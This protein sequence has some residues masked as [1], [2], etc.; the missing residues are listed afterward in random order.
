MKFGRRGLTAA[1]MSLA[2]VA[3]TVVALPPAAL[4]AGSLTVSTCGAGVFGHAAAFG[5]N[6]MMNCPPVANPPAGVSILTGPNKVPAGRRATWLANA[7]AGLSIVGV[8]IPPNDMYSNGVNDGKGW[9]G[10]FYWAGGGAQTHDNEPTFTSPPMNSSYFGFQIVCGASTCDG[11]VSPAQLT[12]ESVNLQATES[13]GPALVASHGL[14]QSQGWVRGNWPLAFSGD[15]PSGICAFNATLNTSLLT[16]PT[17]PQNPTVWHQCGAPAFAQTISTGAYGQGAVPLTLAAIDAA[18]VSGSVSRS[19]DVDNTTPSI[20]LS[21]P[22]DAPTTAGV[23]DVTATASAGPSGVAGT[24]CSL[25]GAP[26]QWHSGASAAIPVQGLGIHAVTCSSANTARD[27]SGNAGWSAPASW[28]LSIRQPS[29]SSISFSRVVNALRCSRTRARVRV[30]AHWVTVTV[31]GRRVRIELPAQTR[32]LALVRCHPRYVTRRVRIGGHWRTVRVPLLPHTVHAS[33]KHV[34]YGGSTTVSGWLG[35]YQG[36]ALGHQ[37]VRIR[38]AP[39]NGQHVFRQVAVATTAA[40]GSWTARLPPGP[41]RIVDAVYDGS[42]TVEP[43]SGQAGVTT[44]ASISLDV[45]P[46]HAHW[47]GRIVLSGRLAGGYLPAAGETVI[48]SVH[49]AGG[50]HDF[51]HVTAR[52]DG[53]FRYVYTF[54]PGIGTAAYP[55]S[56][57]TVRESDY[58]YTP[59]SSRRVTVDVSS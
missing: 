20:A 51:A 17:S 1:A 40:N 5:I 38:T 39:D 31:G 26:A 22:T 55:F 46:R 19:I 52:G 16:G 48:L 42:Q 49:F 27:G 56:A 13:Q 18:G 2:A 45:Q 43:S 30:P 4:G 28:R 9:G 8:S 59:K 29:I 23:Q 37:A 12:V 33:T 50:A 35:T 57:E 21:G 15:S 24:S 7:P 41:S 47:G 3:I 11:S 53:R 14:W 10:G 32:T 6:T 25:D 54:L 44:P 34:P 36:V 58:P